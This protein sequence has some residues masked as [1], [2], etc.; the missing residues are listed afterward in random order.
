MH[1][2]NHSNEFCRWP[3]GVAPNAQGP[4]RKTLDCSLHCFR[5][6]NRNLCGVRSG[7]C[8]PLINFLPMQQPLVHLAIPGL[9]HSHG[10]VQHAG[11]RIEIVDL[12][13]MQT[14]RRMTCLGMREPRSAW[15]RSVP[16][17]RVW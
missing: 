2:N 16:W 8:N 5:T 13:S 1:E 12:D 4:P 3:S 14:L 11:V 9:F 7:L 10:F 6:S 17:E 15:Y